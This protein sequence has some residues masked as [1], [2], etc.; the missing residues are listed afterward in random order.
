MHYLVK[1]KGFYCHYLMTLGRSFPCP[2]DHFPHQRNEGMGPSDPLVLSL[3]EERRG[4]LRPP[5]W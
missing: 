2:E 3:R 5:Y 4:D 1:S